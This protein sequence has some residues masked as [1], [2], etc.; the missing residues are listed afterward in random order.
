M[1]APA[2]PAQV[3]Y[4]GQEQTAAVAGN[5][6]YTISGSKQTNAGTYDITVTLNDAKNYEWSD[7]TSEALT[8]QWTIAK[9]T[10]VI[11]AE[12]AQS[13]EYDGEAQNV[14]A[15][16]AG[17][18]GESLTV[19]VTWYSDAEH[20]NELDGAPVEAG[21]YYAVL[22][23][24]GSDNYTVAQSVNVTFTVTEDA[25]EPVDPVDPDDPNEPED[26][27]GTEEPKGLGGGAIAAIVISCVVLVGLSVTLGVLIHKKKML[28]KPKKK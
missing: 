12:T 2:A 8:L 9:A 20:E 25:D 22:S 1:T 14:A 23:Y 13:A 11:T 28:G 6:A 17:V 5:A 7:G 18:N 4:N 10:P 16:I 19:T 27:S 3:T 26:S 24:A 21:T 15:S